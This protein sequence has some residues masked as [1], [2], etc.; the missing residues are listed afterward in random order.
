MAA[1]RALGAPG[2]GRL[3]GPH[4]PSLRDGGRGARRGASAPGWPSSSPT[5]ACALMAGLIPRTCGRP[6]LPRR[7][8]PRRGPSPP[9]RRP[10]PS[11]RSASSRSPAVVHAGT[12][13]R[14]GMAD[15]GRGWSGHAWRA[16][17]RSWWWPRAGQG[18][19]AAGR[20]RFAGPQPASAGERRA[21]LPA[22]SS[23]HGA[24]RAAGARFGQ[25]GRAERLAL[26]S[27][28]KAA[29]VPGVTAVGL[30]SVLPVSFNGKTTWVRFV[31]RPYHGE[32]NEVNQRD[33]SPGYLATSGTTGR[34]PP[35]HADDARPGRRSRHRQ[36]LAG[37]TSPTRTRSA[38]DRRHLADTRLD[39]RDRRRRRQRP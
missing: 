33:V 34:R 6:A 39:R 24:R 28:G 22:R 30:T 20:R 38:S 1:P 13:V 7:P 3:A 14:A 17:A 36:A 23:R 35:P 27:S 8:R 5:P 32:H 25:P 4:R 29:A 2:A 12:D 11:S 9:A 15:G 31:G 16:S 37:C 26:R 10:S 19:G 18:Y 21:R